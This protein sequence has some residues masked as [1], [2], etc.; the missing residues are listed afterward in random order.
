MHT[1]EKY[2]ITSTKFQTNFNDQKIRNLKQNRF[3]HLELMLG[4]YLGFEIW[5]LGFE[6]G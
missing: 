2:Q 4:I 1:Q 6:R 3:G 5:S